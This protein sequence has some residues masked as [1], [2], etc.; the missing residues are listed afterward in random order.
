MWGVTPATSRYDWNGLKE[1]IKVHGLR[2]SLLLAPMPTASTAQ[3]LGNNESFEPFTS[4][5]YSRR[6]LAGEFAVVNKHLIRDLVK[7][8]LWNAEIRNSV[9]AHGGSIQNIPEIPSHIKAVYK[10][11]WE[12][13]QKK[14]IDMAADRGAYIDQSQSFNIHMSDPTFAKLTSMHFYG[15]KRG[16]KTGMY[17]LRSRP[18]ADAIQFTV[19]Q[20]SLRVRE[21]NENKNKA[22]PLEKSLVNSIKTKLA[23]S[24]VTISSNNSTP[25]PSGVS[26]PS[27]LSSVS[28]PVVGTAAMAKSFTNTTMLKAKFKINVEEDVCLNCGS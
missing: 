19:D 1:S 20:A 3:I 16:L 7:I 5:M 14:L 23:L 15:W 26:T 12:I 10:T 6:V 11:V 2:N 25:I 18:A 13:S 8:G 17:Y 9:I 21:E 4:N 24:D 27:V 22:I 28:S